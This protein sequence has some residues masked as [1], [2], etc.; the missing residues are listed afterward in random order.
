MMLLFERGA[1]LRGAKDLDPR[2]VKVH[3]SLLLA[4]RDVAVL[5]LAAFGA[6]NSSRS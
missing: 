1:D 6:A 5:T 2:F 4:G 3:T